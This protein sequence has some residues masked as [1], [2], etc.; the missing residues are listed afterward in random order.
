[1]GASIS[2]VIITWNEE[3]N[4]R[5]CL[6]SLA[7]IPHPS[8]TIDH[9]PFPIDHSPSTIPHS[10]EIIV[11]DSGSTDRTLDICREY[12]CRIISH[13][14]EGYAR[15]KNFAIS[16]ATGDWILSLDAD[17]EVTPQLA[18]EIRQ[19]VESG[20]A[21]AY[22]MPR[23]NSFLGKW[24]RR[25]GWYPDRQLRLFKRDTG[26]FKLVPLHEYFEPH[27]A[28]ARVGHLRNPLLHY[29]YPTVSDF[30]AKAD[31]YTTIEV[32][33]KLAS[34]CARRPSAFSLSCA[35]PLKFAE[36]YLY[37]LGWLDGL[38]G[39]AAAVLMSFRVFLRQ[40]KLRHAFSPANHK[41]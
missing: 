16:Q 18:D 29:T 27:D 14:W 6:Q 22:D 17:E 4:I 7:T 37:K 5:R 11:V 23:S 40:L 15:Q 13:E 19:V 20:S 32:E 24:M 1:M 9:R 36:V 31:R 25:G 3:A 8:S 10:P 30:V 35:M 28:H 34:G 26:V 33:A 2:V 39:L 41:P 21:E 12:E 38:H